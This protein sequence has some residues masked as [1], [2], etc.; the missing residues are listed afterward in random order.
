MQVHGISNGPPALE[1]SHETL[2]VQSLHAV[3]V[4]PKVYKKTYEQ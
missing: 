4:K 2:R 3:S 1:S